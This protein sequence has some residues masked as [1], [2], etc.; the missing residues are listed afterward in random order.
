MRS[1]TTP[2]PDSLDL[3]REKII[4]NAQDHGW[5]VGTGQN[6]VDSD[7]PRLYACD[8]VEQPWELSLTFDADGGDR[9]K[10]RLGRDIPGWLGSVFMLLRR[11]DTVWSCTG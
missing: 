2:D 7:N 8:V 5:S 1:P 3:L 4:H 6:G 11:A 9:D 10:G